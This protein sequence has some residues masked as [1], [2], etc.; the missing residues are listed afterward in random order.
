MN[1]EPSVSAAGLIAR[2]DPDLMAGSHE[3]TGDL[4][5]EPSARSGDEC[6]RHV[7][8]VRR[9]T[10]TLPRQYACA[11]TAAANAAPTRLR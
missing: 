7:Q 9:V 3:L 1:V 5:A 8:T 10:R 4:E 11:Q 2:A 6:R